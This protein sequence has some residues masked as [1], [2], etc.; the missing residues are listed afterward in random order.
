MDW[1]Q[2]NIVPV[3]GHV[4]AAIH[5]ARGEEEEAEKAFKQSTLTTW[6]YMVGGPAGALTPHMMALLTSKDNEKKERKE[7]HGVS[8]CVFMLSSSYGVLVF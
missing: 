1:N 4:K 7:R 6:G 3:V 2:F 8:F 5:A